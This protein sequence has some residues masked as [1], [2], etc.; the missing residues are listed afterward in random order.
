MET[1]RSSEMS[2]YSYHITRRHIPED[3]TENATDI[4]NSTLRKEL[5]SGIAV[6]QSEHKMENPSPIAGLLLNFIK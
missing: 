6:S 4:F 5:N 1:L 3:R 2:A